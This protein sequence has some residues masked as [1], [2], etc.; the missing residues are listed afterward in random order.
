MN[1]G[2]HKFWIAN[3]KEK[4]K[5]EEFTFAAN[6]SSDPVE[7]KKVIT[8]L[9]RISRLGRHA[10]LILKKLE[11]D[12]FYD[13]VGAYIINRGDAKDYNLIIQTGTFPK[14]K[15]ITRNDIQG[16][17]DYRLEFG[18]L[19]QRSSRYNW[20]NDPDYVPVFLLGQEA[21]MWNGQEVVKLALKHKIGD[22]RLLKK[23]L[24]FRHKRD[25]S[26]N[27]STIKIYTKHNSAGGKEAK[28]SLGINIAEKIIQYNPYDESVPY[29]LKDLRKMIPRWLDEDGILDKLTDELREYGNVQKIM[30]K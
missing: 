13:G 7:A 2:H 5:K 20:T 12:G 21:L 8:S 19:K 18:Q 11:S 17:G 26:Y 27:S 16:F 9:K 30:I 29:S 10:E 15:P 6:N 14:I 24:S 4:E 23:G 1:L 28:N 25:R 3:M 22:V